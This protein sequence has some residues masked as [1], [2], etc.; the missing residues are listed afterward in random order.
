V[1]IRRY[2]FEDA[3]SHAEVHRKSVRGIASADYSNEIID[4]WASKEPEDS[5]LDEEKVRFVAEEDEEIVGFS[6]Y[7]KETNELSG[8]YVKPGHTGKGIGKKLLDKAEEDARK[9]GLERLWCKSTIT[10]KEFYQKHGYKLI[11]ETTHEIDGLEMTVYKME[12][13]L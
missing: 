12:K 9:N 2:N 10:A 11:E 6:D 3:E 13:E 4:A 5:P 8:L 1:K 7:N